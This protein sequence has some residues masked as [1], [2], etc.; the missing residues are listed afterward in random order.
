[1]D[2][3]NITLLNKEQDWMICLS[4]PELKLQKSTHDAKRARSAGCRI[5]PW[6]F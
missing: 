5:V 4:T 2:I 1:M 3:F 6:L